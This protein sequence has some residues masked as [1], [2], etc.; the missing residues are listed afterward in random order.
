[1]DLLVHFSP[2][3]KAHVVGLQTWTDL[4]FKPLHS[5]LAFGLFQ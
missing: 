2:V 4:M 3:K 1:M 5:L